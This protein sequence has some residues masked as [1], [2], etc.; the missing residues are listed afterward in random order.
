MKLTGQRVFYAEFDGRRSKRVI[1]K[2]T[3][4]YP[5]GRQ[6]GPHTWCKAARRRY[7]NWW[8][9]F[10]PN[11][12]A[13]TKGEVVLAGGKEST[14]KTKSVIGGLKLGPVVVEL[15]QPHSKVVG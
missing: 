6:R 12:N 9:A 4:E 10:L 5:L 15:A 8:V 11:D 14:W 1:V 3:G 2:V 13:H 7:L